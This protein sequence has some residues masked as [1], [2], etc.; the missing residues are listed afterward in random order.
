MT[1]VLCQVFIFQIEEPLLDEL[2]ETG[3][4]P[5][6]SA[7]SDSADSVGDDGVDE[8]IAVPEQQLAGEVLNTEYSNMSNTQ[9]NIRYAV[10]GIKI[11]SS[12]ELPSVL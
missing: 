5:R 12:V 2:T 3:T 10:Y 8:S 1:L 9:S 6:M 4:V 7:E 11:R